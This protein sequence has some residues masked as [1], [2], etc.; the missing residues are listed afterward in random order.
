MGNSSLILYNAKIHTLDPIRPWASLIVV[1][2]GWIT[3]LGKDRDL[4]RLRSLGIHC[5]DCQGGSVVPGFHDAHLHLLGLAARL[6]SLNCTPKAIASLATLKETVRRRTREIPIGHWIRGWGY[7]ETA[8][9]EGRHPTRHD[10]DEVS[11]QHPVRLIHRS[12]HGAVL[13]T[14]ALTKG[15]AILRVHDVK[16]AMETIKLVSHFSK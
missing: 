2:E 8:F 4:D 14:L 13:N 12:G 7:D 1:H 5:I 11:L 15:A 10:L 9:I 16:E 6:M 3:F